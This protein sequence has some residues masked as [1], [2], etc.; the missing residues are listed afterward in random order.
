LAVAGNVGVGT[1]S[2]A[3]KLHI[4]VA[5]AAVDGTK[6]VRITNPVGTIAVFECGNAGDSFIG[7]TSGSDFNI[8]T[9]NTVRATF[10]LAG[11]LGLGVTPSAWATSGTI[12]KALQI[13]AA[14]S[15]AAGTV[16]AST[17]ISQ[18]AYFDGTSWRYIQ[19]AASGNYYIAGNTHNW[20]IAGSGT[21]G[22]AISFTQAMT[23]DASGNL[24]VGET[25]PAFRL[26]VK[27]SRATSRLTSSTGTNAVDFQ[28]NNT[29]GQLLLGID[30]STGGSLFGA[31]GYTAGLFYS[32]AYP[33]IFGTNNAEKMRL[34]SD[35]TFRVKGAGTAGSTDAF[36][37]AGTAPADAARITSGGDLLVGKTATTF[38]D[39]GIVLFSTADASGARINVTNTSE[40]SLNLNRL[41]TDGTIASFSRSTTS[42]GSIS[43]T[44]VA[45]LFN[46]TSDQRLKENIVD[47]PDFG[48]VIDSIQVRSFDWKAN[49]TNQRAGFVAQELLTV[50][51]EA[52]HQP[53]DPEEMMA[54]DY[55]KLVPMLVK[56]I[57][58][59]RA[60]VASLESSTLQ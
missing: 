15:I 12:L 19:S 22:N 31:G 58:D 21:A 44:T 13:G 29:G 39:N 11:N 54:V 7:T 6:G 25:N 49:S 4:A 9:G 14:G 37:V 5:S 10:D 59:L 45:T 1:A 47:A 28:A 26:D 24:G 40:A 56:E 51:P 18:N 46:T 50:A 3:A 38:S 48:S 32:G 33:L 20:R 17:H 16:D 43:V 53:A 36:Q 27:A 23:L 57:Q 42:V 55:S 35:G 60:R 52:V 41:S 30:S 8:R 34:S 2:P